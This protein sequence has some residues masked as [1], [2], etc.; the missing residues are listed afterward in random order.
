[1]LPLTTGVPIR[2]PESA[3]GKIIFQVPCDLRTRISVVARAAA[4][5][6]SLGKPAQSIFE[7][8]PVGVDAKIFC[9]KNFACF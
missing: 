3:E 9:S 1:M 6:H 2:L 5:L 8:V 4:I 7:S